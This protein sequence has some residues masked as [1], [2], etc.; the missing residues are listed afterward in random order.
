[1]HCGKDSGERQRERKRGTAEGERSGFKKESGYFHI[2]HE[3]RIRSA[4]FFK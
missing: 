3:R 2:L 4:S 1:M